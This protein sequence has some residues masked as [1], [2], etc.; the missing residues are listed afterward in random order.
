[1]KFKVHSVDNEGFANWVAKVKQS[2]Q[3]LNSETLKQLQEKTKDHPIEYFSQVVDQQF[4]K[5]I[6]KYSGA[7]NVE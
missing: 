4:E 5:L 1:M 7:K 2:E 6:E 3:V